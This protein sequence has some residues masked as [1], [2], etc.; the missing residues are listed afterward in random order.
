MR[1]S[2]ARGGLLF[3]LAT[4]ACGPLALGQSTWDNDPDSAPGFTNSVFHTPSVDSINLYNGQITVPIAVGPSY[5]LGPKLKYQAVLT[6]NSYGP[7]FPN[8]VRPA[9][10][11]MAGDTAFGIGW[12]FTLGA[13]KYLPNV[14]YAYIAPDGSQH[15]FVFSGAGSGYY[16]TTDATAYYLH[17]NGVGQNPRWEMWDGD[18]N[19]YSFGQAVAGYDDDFQSFIHDYGRGRDG[20]YL[21]QLTDPYGNGLTATYPVTGGALASPCWV[22]PYCTPDD[23]GFD[24]PPPN[25][26]RCNGSGPHWVPQTISLTSG[27]T[28]TVGRKLQSDPVSN[29]G[30]LS[31]L[32]GSFT[33]EMPVSGVQTSRTWNLDYSE[34]HAASACG[35]G[36][37]YYAYRLGTIRLPSDLALSPA[38]RFEYSSCSGLMSRLT[39][40]TGG[41]IDYTWGQYYFY[42]GRVSHWGC[43]PTGVQG[44]RPVKVSGP[45]SCGGFQMNGPVGGDC[46]E[47]GTMDLDTGTI[48]VISR[49]ETD[50]I[51]AVSGTTTYTQYAFPFGEHDTHDTASYNAQSLTVVVFPPDNDGKVR[52][53]SVLFYAGP[54]TDVPFPGDRTGADLREA[55]YDFAVPAYAPGLTQPACNGGTDRLFC[56]NHAV[57]VTNRAFEY[58]S[59]LANRHL[60]SETRIYGAPNALGQCSSCISHTVSYSNFV[61]RN[62]DAFPG[63]TSGNGRHYN[64]ETHSGNLGGVGADTKSVSTTWS[65]LPAAS[66]VL[67][68][69][70][71]LYDKRI[72]TDASGTLR[73]YFDY[74]HSAQANGFLRGI[75]TWDD[76]RGRLFGEC[77][78]RKTSQGVL[79][80]HGN[81]A[82]RYTA[83][84]TWASEPNDANSC[85]ALLPEPSSWGTGPGTNGD[86]FATDFTYVNGQRVTARAVNGGAQAPW[87]TYDVSRDTK[88]GWITSSRDTAGLQTNFLYDSL[89]RPTSITPPGEA[90]TSISYD[91][92][93]QTTATRNGGADSSTWNQY[94]Y[95]GF[96]R[97]IRAKRQMPGGSYVKRFTRFDPRGNAFFQSEWVSDGTAETYTS[98]IGATCDFSTGSDSGTL[99]TNVPASAPGVHRSCFDP[100]GRPQLLTGASYSSQTSLSRADVRGGYTTAS[101]SDTKETATVVCVNGTLSSGTPHCTGGSDAT[102]TTVKDGYGRITKVTEPT[103]DDTTYGHDVLSKLSSVSQGAQPGRSFSYDR[104][105]FLRSEYSPEKGSVTYDSIGSCGN[106]L[107]ETQP[108]S[109]VITRTFDYA[110]RLKAVLSSEGRT[111]LTNTYDEGGHGY[112]AGKLTTSVSNNWALS[113]QSAVTD[114]FTYSG[115]G[116]RLSSKS[117][118]LSG[119]ASLPTTQSF[120]YSTLGLL[121]SHGHPRKSG[122][123]AF[124][125]SYTF[126]A[127]LPVTEL[128]N[129]ATFVSGITYGASGNLATYTT[130]NGAGHSVTTTIAQDG[131]LPR[132]SRI[133]T[134]GATINFDSGTYGYDGAGNVKTAGTD[135][136]AYDGRSRL[137][138]ADIKDYQSVNH[139][140]DFTYDRWG[141]ISYR[142]ADGSGYTFSID[143][144]TNRLY[145]T[146]TQ[147]DPRGNL[148]SYA[149]SQYAYD[150]LSRQTSYIVTG[151]VD[152]RYLYDAAGERMGRVVPGSTTVTGG[153]F[154]PITPCRL[155]DSRVNTPA[156]AAAS[157]RT[158]LAWNACGIPSTATALAS[159]V[160]SVNIPA[161]GYLRAYPAGLSSRPLAWVNAFRY[162]QATATQAFISINGPTPGSFTL[163]GDFPFGAVDAIVDVDGYVGAQSISTPD[164]YTL[165]L[166]D[167]QNR[168]ATKYTLA[169]G[170]SSV[171]ADYVYVGNQLVA[172]CPPT[173]GCSFFVTDHLG[174][175]RLQTDVSATTVTRMKTRA[176]GL[177]LTGTLPDGSDFA[178]MEKD[179][180][181]GNHYDHARYYMSWVAR[182]HSPDQLGGHPEDPQSWNR[183]AY[184]RNNPLKYVDP[185][186]RKEMTFVV[187]SFIQQPSVIAPGFGSFRGDARGFSLSPGAGFRTQQTIR[188]ETD[189]AKRADPLISYKAE[190]GPSQ[191]VNTGA[192][193]YAAGVSGRDS[194][195]MKVSRDS[196]GNVVID[197]NQNVHNPLVPVGP[198]IRTDM[199]IT[200]SPSGDTV[201]AAGIT[202]Q[203]PSFEV[204]VQSS[205]G[206]FSLFQSNEASP[207][208]PGL[209]GNQSFGAVCQGA[210][211]ASPSCVQA[212]RP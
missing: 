180:S 195:S 174:T 135:V 76:G 92:P 96:G 118:T 192:T 61:G 138:G 31:N 108:G 131:N 143:T 113:T 81:V 67:P 73:Q 97:T 20:W 189:P 109:L 106:V 18:G 3:I 140:E 8:S 184:A 68:W 100:Y 205:T 4:I 144:N 117:Q 120:T 60:Q 185:D 2:F 130:N 26:M 134:S 30:Y 19:H 5:P 69:F 75:R 176:F 198:G 194:M 141:N 136:F 82:S 111:Y 188:V 15:V 129:G 47:S 65:P 153:Y 166:R 133:S 121:S 63:D 13:I 35:G 124:T 114:S 210:N 191:N 87:L 104:F 93:T 119:S 142:S 64:V 32:I 78:Y 190:V 101:Y 71:N 99:S 167:P 39:L 209:F 201:T 207:F 154:Y 159:N 196:S 70:P 42:H 115:V 105:G 173:G 14:G 204:N 80:S 125:L 110:N 95:D 53:K 164:T 11:L 155:F 6:Y 179:A 40:P 62:W 1:G 51:T 123:A 211:S 151:S 44:N 27:V 147:Y 72:T 193:D 9:G 46:S 77:L 7:D 34:G 158:V 36:Q 29:V 199:T 150:G 79:D 208:A 103:G 145:G 41:T 88:T 178:S 83:T 186:G 146:G 102:T 202:G 161:N 17:D 12:S 50:P 89:G 55:D 25:Q 49:V 10:M 181:S 139:H 48:G 170:V 74:D 132:P 203:S 24:L 116:G 86:A 112:A 58:D 54:T 33:F 175:P 171:V 59:G 22:V 137:S 90:A 45:I 28:I 107:Q 148:T 156:I 43:N 152:E 197:Q 126:S 163:Y 183:Y 177:N 122:D 206:S 57:R 168:L 66:N 160:T 149:G 200:A 182:F 52:S 84:F 23:P 172:K 21:T 94:Q 16:K 212:I 38:Y 127:G 187:R 128:V 169:S 37:N 56:P 91:S 157:Q 98:N 162:N 85:S 165:S